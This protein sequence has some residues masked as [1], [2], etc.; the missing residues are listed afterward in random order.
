MCKLKLNF[1]EF[2]DYIENDYQPIKEL[3]SEYKKKQKVKMEP[4]Q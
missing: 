4:Q 3:F 2:L 1:T